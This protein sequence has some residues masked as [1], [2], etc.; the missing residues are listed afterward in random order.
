MTWTGSADGGRAPIWVTF[1][2]SEREL[3][4]EKDHFVHHIEKTGVWVVFA[5]RSSKDVESKIFRQ[6]RRLVF[7]EYVKKQ[8][9][10]P[11]GV[12]PG[13]EDF[14]VSWKDGG[15]PQLR[16]VCGLISEEDPSFGSLLADL[17]HSASRSG[18]EQPMDLCEIFKMI[19][20]LACKILSMPCPESYKGKQWVRELI[21][22]ARSA[23]VLSLDSIKSNSI[24][25][26]ITKLP[27]L[28]IG[29]AH[30]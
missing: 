27:Q 19:H 24:I 26:L 1:F 30:V 12:S 28:E 22:Q 10:M 2:V 11:G 21:S 7:D 25:D 3:P 14:S 13:S 4:G 5:R 6:Y 23:G 15:G 8:R 18:M 16:A 29:R 17:K 20:A 9:G